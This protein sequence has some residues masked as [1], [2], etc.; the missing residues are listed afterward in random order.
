MNRGH[1]NVAIGL[2]R[3]KEPGI[4]E[5]QF[6]QRWG[7]RVPNLAVVDEVVQLLP[8]EAKGYPLFG[9]QGL[10]RRNWRQQRAARRSRSREGGAL[11]N[12]R[13]F[14]VVLVENNAQAGRRKGMP[15]AEFIF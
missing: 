4:I 12:A 2:R 10:I 6:H 1:V 14:V 7:Q 9:W 3:A 8:Q 5:T 15:V 11:I 13:V